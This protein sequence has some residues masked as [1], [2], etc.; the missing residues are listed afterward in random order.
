MTPRLVVVEI[1]K[2]LSTRSW[3][4]TAL[5]L[6]AVTAGAVAVMGLAAPYSDPPLPGIDTDQGVRAAVGV[7]A[8]LAIVPALVGV[9]GMT[10]EYQHQTITPAFLAVPRRSP[11]V[12]AKVVA[13]AVIGAGYGVVTAVAVVASLTGSALL[14][15][16]PLGAGAAETAG[17]LVRVVAAMTVYTMIGVGVGALVR[18]QLAAIAVLGGVLYFLDQVLLVVPGVNTVYPYLPGGATAALTDF[19]LLAE[20]AGSETGL[21]MPDL[22]SPGA[23]A[24]VLAGYALVAVVVAVVLPVRRDVV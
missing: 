8:F 14:L 19:T 2:F 4:W 6:A 10:S 23:G 11:V 21:A 15:D 9:V 1:E 22:L 24:A 18:H 12:V 13:Y 16:V 20:Q 5:L 17:M 3:L 7:T